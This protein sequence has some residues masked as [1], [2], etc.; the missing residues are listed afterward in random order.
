[1]KFSDLKLLYVSEL[2]KAKR[3]ADR[4]TVKFV[5]AAYNKV[6][7]I[8]NTYYDDNDTV[9]VARIDAL[10]I[11]KHMKMK[12]AG[13]SK[14][15]VAKGLREKKK[16]EKLQMDLGNLLGIGRA[17]I[18]EL[19]AAGLN[20][21]E[22]LNQKK[23]NDMLNADTRLMLKYK[24]LRKISH[25]DIK[26]IEVKLTAFPLALAQLVGSFRRRMPY[27]KDIDILLRADSPEIMNEYLKYLK[28]SF[29]NRVYIYSQGDDKMSLIIQPQE[30]SPKLSYKLDIFRAGSDTYYT[31]LLY[32]T[33]PK[34][35]N[36]R[37]RG[38]ARRMGYLL[39]QNGLFRKSGSRMKKINDVR[40]D[41][42]ALFK[43]LGMEYLA[44]EKRV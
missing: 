10:P 29:G 12:L 8:I 39:N 2:E 26:K 17:K 13:L 4:K 1:M 33:G 3:E 42:K 31:N 23:F 5:A 30:R 9:T 21:I 20:D 44:P 22:Q 32:S 19:L 36:I 43:Y 15:S 14:K 24:P 40:D 16:A 28:K 7:K 6:L 18:N 35:F 41:E 37:M 25:T 27:S 38:R 11:T 34:E